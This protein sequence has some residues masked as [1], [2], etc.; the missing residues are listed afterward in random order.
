MYIHNKNAFQLFFAVNL[1][2]GAHHTPYSA[3]V[4]KER[5]FD[6]FTEALFIFRCVVIPV[7]RTGTF[8]VL[9]NFVSCNQLKLTYIF[10]ILHLTFRHFHSL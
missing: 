7:Y 4:K 1:I 10:E 5:M 8:S 3:L 6:L 9:F 2:K